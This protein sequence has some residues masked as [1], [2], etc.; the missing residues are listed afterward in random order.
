MVFG[1]PSTTT[2]RSLHI[3]RIFCTKVAARPQVQNNEA[4]QGG[5][6]RDKDLIIVNLRRQ[7]TSRGFSDASKIFNPELCGT[8]EAALSRG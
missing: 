1:T 2:I 5:K 8:S 7:I 3:G 6:S 4:C